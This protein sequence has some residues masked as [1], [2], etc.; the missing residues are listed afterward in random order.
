MSCFKEGGGLCYKWWGAQVTDE[1]DILIV[2]NGRK[3]DFK[4]FGVNVDFDFLYFLTKD[5][6]FVYAAIVVHL[7]AKSFIY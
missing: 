1:K 6:G 7:P 2:A 4:L 5:H 3:I